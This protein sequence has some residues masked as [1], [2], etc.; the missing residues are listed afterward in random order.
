M[1]DRDAEDLSE[2]QRELRAAADEGHI[3]AEDVLDHVDS[4]VNHDNPSPEQHHDLRQ[5]LSDAVLHFE[6]THPTLSASLERVANSL[7]AAGI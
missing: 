2:L 5:R 3:E 7:S 4:Y 6:V 1:E